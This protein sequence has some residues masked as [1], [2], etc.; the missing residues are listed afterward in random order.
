MTY[1]QAWIPAPPPDVGSTKI[2]C[3]IMGIIFG[4][5]GVHR[6]I[7]GDVG[8]G[9]LRIVITVFTCGLGAWIGVAEGII[10]LTKTDSDF[11]RIYMVEKRSWF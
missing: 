7:L 5:L 10:Y 1:E 3:G 6:F 8:G 11:Y 2:L 9:I 4:G